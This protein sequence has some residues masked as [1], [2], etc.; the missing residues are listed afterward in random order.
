MTTK[1]STPFTI[2]RTSNLSSK[3]VAKLRELEPTKYWTLADAPVVKI[4]NQV[5]EMRSY[6]ST[7]NLDYVDVTNQEEYII[8][9]VV[10]QLRILEYGALVYIVQS[11][12]LPQIFP[13]HGSG[14]AIPFYVRY[15]EAKE[16]HQTVIDSETQR[17]VPEGDKEFRVYSLVDEKGNFIDGLEDADLDSVAN[18]S[19]QIMPEYDTVKHKLKHIRV[20]GEYGIEPLEGSI[21][22][23]T[24]E[25]IRL[26]AALRTTLTQLD[27]DKKYNVYGFI[28]IPY[29]DTNTFEYKVILHILYSEVS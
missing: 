29:V 2:P 16:I 10:D 6:R 7:M 17:S 24:E 28:P 26:K 12:A 27:F 15:A 23:N 1:P 8:N 22:G 4:E 13:E 18:V 25:A 20:L 9:Y 21:E 19:Y 5:Y 11:M 14:L 3:I